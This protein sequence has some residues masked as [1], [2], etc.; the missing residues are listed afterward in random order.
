MV[1]HLA[2]YIY[3]ESQKLQYKLPVHTNAC[4]F[5]ENTSVTGPGLAK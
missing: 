1:F 4:L 5:M 3:S 2:V